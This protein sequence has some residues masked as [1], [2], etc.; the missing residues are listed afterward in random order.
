MKIPGP[1][2]WSSKQTKNEVVYLSTNQSE[3]AGS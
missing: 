2:I 3:I 1:K